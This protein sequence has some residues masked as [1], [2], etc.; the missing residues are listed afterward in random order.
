MSGITEQDITTALA[1]FV[2]AKAADPFVISCA[3]AAVDLVTAY[4]GRDLNHV[5]EHVLARAMV[6][7]GADLF[8]RRAARNGVVAFD[9]SEMAASPIRIGRDPLAAAR[10]ILA[11]Y[12]RIGIA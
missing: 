3:G 11:P 9:D 7:V 2:G 4:A 6:E 10:P 5:P 12:A 1:P 8:H